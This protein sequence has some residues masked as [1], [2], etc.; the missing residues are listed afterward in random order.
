MTTMKP[1]FY[2]ARWMGDG[3]DAWETVEVSPPWGGCQ[4]VHLCGDEQAQSVDDFEFG[5][6]LPSPAE[7]RTPRLCS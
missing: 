6:Y 2:W 4:W 5:P 1:G 3:H 7:A